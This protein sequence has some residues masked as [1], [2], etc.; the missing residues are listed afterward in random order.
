MHIHQSEPS[1]VNNH[2]TGLLEWTTGLTFF[3]QKIIFIAYNEI[4]LLV[5]LHS[6][7]ND[8]SDVCIAAR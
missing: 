4:P 1:A 6:G 3:A 5:K 7:V 8:L 2:W